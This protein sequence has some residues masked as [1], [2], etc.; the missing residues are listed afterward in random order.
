MHE[1]SPRP[2][3]VLRY[4]F[5]LRGKRYIDLTEDDV[6]HI[7]GFGDDG[8]GEDFP[9]FPMH[10]RVPGLLRPLQPLQER[11]SAME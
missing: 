5:T 2:V 1:A 10:D 7:R 9:R 3:Q 8:E 6:F 11:I 4:T